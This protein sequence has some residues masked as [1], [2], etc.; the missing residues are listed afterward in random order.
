VARQHAQRRRYQS[1]LDLPRGCDETIS[2]S[3]LFLGLS[4]AEKSAAP[5]CETRDQGDVRQRFVRS[6]YASV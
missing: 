3:M 5:G 2:S 6:L 1:R 4:R